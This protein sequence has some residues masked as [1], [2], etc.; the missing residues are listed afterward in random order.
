MSKLLIVDDEKKIRDIYRRRLSA[1]GF[2]IV[3][4]ENGEEATLILIQDKGIDLFLLDIRMPVIDGAS[5]FDAARLYNPG[6]KIIVSSVY[7]LSDQIR[8]IEGA[9]DYFDKSEGMDILV[10]KIRSVL[11]LKTGVKRE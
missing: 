4:A 10:E 11:R 9:D 6:A 8:M 5:F 1:E 7:P 2:E 3:E